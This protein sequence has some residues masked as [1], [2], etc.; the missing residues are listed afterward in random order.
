MNILL[1]KFKERD[2]LSVALV[3][4]VVQKE[5][6]GEILMVG[7]T[8]MAGY[9][10]TLATGF[11]VFWSKTRKERWK[12]GEGSGDTIRITDVLIDCDG[13]AVI[14]KATENTGP[15]CHTKAKSCFFRRATCPDKTTEEV[16]KPRTDEQLEI[17]DAQV[18]FSLMI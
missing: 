3:D 10:E 18:H 11:A 6:S 16:P 4:V 17:I 14:Y 13:D 9:L 5:Q 2:N 8:D 1:P 15:V 12:K 7:T